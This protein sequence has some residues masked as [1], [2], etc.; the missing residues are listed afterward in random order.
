ML[1]VPVLQTVATRF[2]EFL[3]GP[4][5]DGAG[6]FSSADVRRGAL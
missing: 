1:A 6:S 5:K 2:V 3:T 4:V